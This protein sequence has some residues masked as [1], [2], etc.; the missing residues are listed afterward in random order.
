MTSL[1]TRSLLRKLP[2]KNFIPLVPIYYQQNRNYCFPLLFC[3]G[4]IHFYCITQYWN[5][6][7]PRSYLSNLLL[8]SYTSFVLGVIIPDF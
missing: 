7:F 5:P 2:N 8:F 1:L 6:Y 3:S 4:V